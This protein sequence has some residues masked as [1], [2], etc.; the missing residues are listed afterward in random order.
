LLPYPS[1]AL[2]K[3]VLTENKRCLPTEPL[4]EETSG[5]Q[6]H[7]GPFEAIGTETGIAKLFMVKDKPLNGFLYSCVH[8]FM[9]NEGSDLFFE[10]CWVP[11]LP[12][13][14]LILLSS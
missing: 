5:L 8:G 10:S 2:L 6:R 9:K 1:S 3:Y 12:W 4:D 7:L 13:L 11:P 14:C